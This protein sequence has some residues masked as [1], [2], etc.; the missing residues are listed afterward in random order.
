MDAELILGAKVLEPVVGTYMSDELAMKLALQEATKGSG[1]VSPNPLVGCVVLDQKNC[2]LSKGYHQKFGEAHAEVN[3]LKNL[4]SAQLQGARVF[5]TL[6]PCSHYGKTPPC[7]EM[8]KK[9][10]I[11]EVV[12]GL[13]DP[14][15]KV[16]GAGIQLL[17]QA[18]IKV[19]R[20]QGMEKELTD[21][22]EH[23][24]INQ[25]H[26]RAFV[27]G[28]IATSLDGFS[29]LKSGE[30]QWITNS[31]SRNFSHYLRSLHDAIAVGV[32]TIKQDNPNLNV[33][34]HLHRPQKLVIF[35]RQ[36]WVA[37][38]FDKLKISTHYRREQVILLTE[39]V[40]QAQ[41]LGFLALQSNDDWRQRLW[42]LGVFSVF[43]EG[44]PVALS[45]CLDSKLLDRLYVFQ[46]P[47]L[48]GAVQGRSWT[49]QV[50]VYKLSEKISLQHV[51]IKAFE[52][53]VLFTAR[54]NGPGS[55]AP[56]K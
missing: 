15:P 25:L 16:S 55:E 56:K 13:Q 39:K 54:I 29:G 53:D 11:A 28:K 20:I 36:A 49:E 37:D 33:R 51:R 3:A 2:F 7:A 8:L 22:C 31:F 14:N 23:F 26:Q 50:K 1:F 48:L 24:L 42:Q 30:S 17:A 6:E 34:G 45:S 46:A 43:L 10:P 40:E 4:S 5:V 41:R 21:L 52:G 9:F 44:G 38:N 47:I 35:D 18:G 19:T 12:Y 32:G 27:S